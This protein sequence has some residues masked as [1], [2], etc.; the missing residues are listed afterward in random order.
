MRNFNKE[1]I[2]IAIIC[3]LSACIIIMFNKFSENIFLVFKNIWDILIKINE[4]IK[5]FYIGIFVAIL[6]NPIMKYIEKTIS[7]S[8]SKKLNKKSIRNISVTTSYVLVLTMLYII[9]MSIIPETVISTSNFISNI[10]ENVSG[11]KDISDSFIKSESSKR[12]L[13]TLEKLD[14]TFEEYNIDIVEN[15]EEISNF[16]VTKLLDSMKKFPNIVDSF[17]KGTVNT[18][19]GFVQ[20]ILSFV[21]AFYILLDKEYLVQKSKKILSNIIGEKKSEFIIEIMHS[22]NEVFEK[23][24]I[25]KI[26]DSLI[27]GALFYF[28]AKLFNLEYIGLSATIMTV[29]NM[30]PYF[31]PFIGGVPIVIIALTQGFVPGIT[32]LILVLALQQFDGL[33]LGPKIISQSTGLR[34]ITVIISIMIGGKLAGPIGMFVAVPLSAVLINTVSKIYE[35][36]GEYKNE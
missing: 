3:V 11:I 27:I 13:E 17:F 20:I 35:I 14:S 22:A 2:K 8:L 16:F 15:E 28:L 12:I 29:T 10:P 19:K 25:G 24:F 21:L 34:P 6:I 9:F 32:A 1:H 7:K 33:V 36:K 23:F 26:I 31:G 30:I 4:T 18:A 5:P